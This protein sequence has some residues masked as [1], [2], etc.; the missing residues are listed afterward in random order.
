MAAWRV[1]NSVTSHAINPAA[2]V[3]PQAQGVA[4]AAPNEDVPHSLLGELQR[5]FPLS[6]V[7]IFLPDPQGGQCLC[8]LDT[9]CHDELLAALQPSQALCVALPADN[10]P[11]TKQGRTERAF[12]E[13]VVI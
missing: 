12:Q 8:C 2:R 1:H 11:G 9:A 3:V 7:D 6:V 10:L 13:A 4:G 5:L